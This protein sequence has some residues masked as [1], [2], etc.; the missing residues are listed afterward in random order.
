M[1]MMHDFFKHRRSF[2]DLQMAPFT[3]DIGGVTW[4]S[5]SKDAHAGLSVATL[6]FPQAIAYSIVAGLSPSAGLFGSIFGV[7]I[8]ALLG[9]SR[10]LV[11]GP[12]SAT[13][14]LI[15]AA[16]S[17]VLY[18]FH[19]TVDLFMRQEI[20]L[21]L[22]AGIALLIGFFQ[23]MASFF[24]LGRLIQFVSYSV[25]I[26]YLL[27]TV[28]GIII[29]Q[30]FP[31]CG[32]SCPDSLDTLYLKLR[33][34]VSNLSEVSMATIVSGAASYFL[35]WFL[36]KNGFGLL[37]PIAMLILA[38]LSVLFFNNTALSD[39]FGH[40]A[41][42]GGG[43][44]TH[45]FEGF[46][47]PTIEFQTMNYLIPVAF[48]L[49][50]MGMLETNSIAKTISSNTGEKLSSNQEL[51]AL[52]CTNSFLSLFR[53]L[54]C[55]GSLARSTLNIDGGNQTRFAAC[56]AGVFVLIA[57]L[58]T[59]G[60]IQYLPQS[61]IAAFLF[62]IVPK[63]VD[64][65]KL[66]QC[67]RATRSDRIVL[68]VTLVSCL[69]LSLHI[70]FYVGIMLSIV[71]YLKKASTP[72]LS[73]W[74]YAPEKKQ[75]RPVLF[76]DDMKDAPIRIIKVE[77]ELFFGAVDMFHHVVRAMAEEDAS[78]KVLILKLKHVHDLD[79]NFAIAIRQM[80]DFAKSCN[81]H[82]LIDS[83]P[84]HV[85]KLLDRTGVSQYIGQENLFPY[86]AAPN[87]FEKTY[88]RAQEI[89]SESA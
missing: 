14:M 59:G 10:H 21:G 82:L 26:G 53:G 87:S 18:R 76:S 67:Y 15:Q 66:V 51:F 48:A 23:L 22:M 89:L 43:D 65:Q 17:E 35:L 24:K 45:T 31:L 55:S 34:L 60:L 75:L 80:F 71:L 1:T 9:S 39:H 78:L 57:T 64:R 70:A 27:G 11:L 36:K 52:G 74:I 58:C 37:A 81:K 61:S 8:A 3:K 77:G 79:V 33:Y 28:I 49:A 25:V 56:L 63:M 6:A 83:I 86:E 42:I 44:V 54:P 47:W 68:V 72:R 84:A 40:I 46:H 69:F 12:S 32:V 85:T 20:A 30:L 5:L 62:S 4:S 50:V 7:M 73:E 29:S 2:D 16:A 38:T 13:I 19:P 41:T 88:T